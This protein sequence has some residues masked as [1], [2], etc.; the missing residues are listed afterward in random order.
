MVLLTASKPSNE[1][2]AQDIGAALLYIPNFILPEEATRLYEILYREIPWKQFMGNFGKFRP[3][4]ES[5]HGDADA[6]YG[7]YN[8]GMRPQPWTP[9]LLE[10]RKPVE[11]FTSLSLN[12][13]LLNLYRDEHDSVAAHSDDEPEFGHNPTIASLS[14]NETRRLI[15]RNIATKEKHVMNLAHG[16]LLVMR[17]DC[18]SAWTHEVQK[19]LSHRHARINLTFRRMFGRK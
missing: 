13:V 7:S 12:G 8:G 6:V 19:E 10:I 4:L 18:Q 17:G 11:E 2:V 9:V 1:E 14:F 16:S 15:F 3:R 5:W